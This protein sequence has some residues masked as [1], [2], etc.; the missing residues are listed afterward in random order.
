MTVIFYFNRFFYHQN[1]LNFIA[2]FDHHFLEQFHFLCEF[3]LFA[4]KLQNLNLIELVAHE[5]FSVNSIELTVVGGYDVLNEIFFVEVH[6]GVHGGEFVGEVF[7]LFFGVFLG[8]DLVF[9]FIDD[10]MFF[11]FFGG[12]GFFFD[13]FLR[14]WRGFGDYWGFGAFVDEGDLIDVTVFEGFDELFEFIDL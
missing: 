14:F 12:R 1:F 4:L 11:L 6:G 7:T 10:L 8:F 5:N 2:F 3:L 9:D 13:G